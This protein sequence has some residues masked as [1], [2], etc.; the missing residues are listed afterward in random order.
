MKSHSGNR[1]I[2]YRRKQIKFFMCRSHFSFMCYLSWLKANVLPKILGIS[3]HARG[4]RDNLYKQECIPVGCV[5]PACCPYIPECTAP[6][7]VPCAGGCTWCR[8][9]LVSGG[10]PGAR[11]VYLVPGGCTWCQGVYLVPGGV[12]GP[13]GVHGPRG[14]TWSQ[15]GY[16]VLGVPAQVPPPPWTE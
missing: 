7:G 15:R 11:G 13:K 3:T 5:P 2:I 6:G 8:V 4:E 1:N 9:Y 16:L 14:G 10:V 12:P